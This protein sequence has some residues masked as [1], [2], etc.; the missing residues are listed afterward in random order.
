MSDES[1]QKVYAK[2]HDNGY[3]EFPVYEV[4]IAAR[5]QSTSDY[6]EVIFGRKPEVPEFYT[7]QSDLYVYDGRVRYDY[8]VIPI[9]LSTLLRTANNVTGSDLGTNPDVYF[10]S[11]DLALATRIYT[12]ISDYVD[13]KLEE[14]VKS[15]S[16]KSVVSCVSYIGDP[17]PQFDAD[18]LKMKA[19][20]SQVWT[21]MNA[22]S[23]T[24][25]NN[26]IPIPKTVA[27]IDTNIPPLS[28]D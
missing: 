17:N 5:N 20:R 4:N 25:L 27:D 10:A 6:Q 3:I 2:V 23:A 22:Y 1:N 28:W 11:I 15:R 19:L 16:Y 18:A 26:T 21:T 9:P 14:F 24:I 13:N 8:S 12:L 7:L